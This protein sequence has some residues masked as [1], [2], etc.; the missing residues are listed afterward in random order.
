VCPVG[1]VE[2]DPLI[3][4]TFNERIDAR[5]KIHE[6]EVKLVGQG[7]NCRVE[8]VV[9]VGIVGVDVVNKLI[10]LALDTMQNR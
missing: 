9:L 3:V 4:R 5:L 10:E 6:R 2:N 7:R 8:V 1:G